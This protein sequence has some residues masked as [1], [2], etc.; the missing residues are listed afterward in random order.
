M[1][2]SFSADRKTVD[3]RFPQLHQAIQ[4][5]DLARAQECIQSGDDV[6]ECTYSG[7]SALE[8]AAEQGNSE[9]IR[10]LLDAGANPNYSQSE[11]PL[12]RAVNKG[13]IEAVETLLERGANIDEDSFGGTA[14]RQAV[15]KG[16]LEIVQ[17]LVLAGAN[18]NVVDEDGYTVLDKVAE[19][20]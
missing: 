8:L 10:T 15:I 16:N 17:L 20:G 1:S 7:E 4:M 11:V 2:S 9:I 12:V 14:L 19:I 3:R 13:N 18:I 6:E 5:G